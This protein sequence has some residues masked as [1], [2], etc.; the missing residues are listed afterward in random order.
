MS[1]TKTMRENSYLFGGSA[2]LDSFYEDYLKDPSSVPEHLKTYFDSLKKDGNGIDVSHADVR[3]YF[4]NH[5]KQAK[6]TVASAD[7]S[8]LRKQAQVESLINAYRSHGHHHA[9]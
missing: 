6:T 4:Y 5:A 2:Y 7:V 8:Q 1:I 9:K 3:N